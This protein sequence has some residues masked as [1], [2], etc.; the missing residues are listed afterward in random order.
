MHGSIHAIHDKRVL[1]CPDTGPMVSSEADGNDLLT[2][3]MGER[4]DV[5]VLPA[6]RLGDDFLRLRTGVAGAIVQKFVNYRIRL[7]IVGDIGTA[8]EKS[9]ALRDFVREANK[10]Q[11]F[12]VVGSLDDVARK[13]S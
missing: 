1:V 6:S 7:A 11:V 13:M 4:A 3:A 5:L 10:G 9:E 8:L 2:A 12:W